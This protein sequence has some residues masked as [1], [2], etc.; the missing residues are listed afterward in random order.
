MDAGSK[1]PPGNVVIARAFGPMFFLAH[2]TWPLVPV[3]AAITVKAKS[4]ENT[5]FMR[6]SSFLVKLNLKVSFPNGFSDRMS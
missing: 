4:V 1:V 3:K 5:L 2:F 6:N